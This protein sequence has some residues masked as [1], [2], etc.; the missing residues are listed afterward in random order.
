[1]PIGTIIKLYLLTAAVCF[2]LDM[3]WLGV[4]ARGF[5]QRQLA[6]ILRP[7]IQWG[8]AVAFYLLFV[9][10]VLVFAVVPALER[11]SLG[12]AIWSGALL[13]LIAY[14]TYDLTNLALARGFPAI[15]AVVDM[16][17]GATIAAMVAAAGYGFGRWLSAL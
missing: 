13:G 2:G 12:R 9:V 4:V 11:G 1:M 15:V 14:A 8:P 5:Y 16:A 17:W 6:A 3:L 7:D 10:G